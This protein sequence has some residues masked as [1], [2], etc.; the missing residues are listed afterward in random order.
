MALKGK[1]LAQ[2]Y[3][4]NTRT[5]LYTPTLKD[6]VAKVKFFALVNTHT[7]QVCVKIYVSTVAII[8]QG[9]DICPPNMILDDG[10]AAYLIDDGQ[11]LDLPNG[12]AILGSATENNLVKFT[13]T[14]EEGPP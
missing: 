1:I 2:G 5:V 7:A 14:G 3:L 4:R 10:D 13:I 8:S 6:V 12:S 9:W 11:E